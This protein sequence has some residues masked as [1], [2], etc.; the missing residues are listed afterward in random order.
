M[1]SSGLNQRATS[2]VALPSLVSDPWMM[3]LDE[4]VSKSRRRERGG[5]RQEKREMIFESYR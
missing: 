1:T 4:R 3:L 2:R 5:E